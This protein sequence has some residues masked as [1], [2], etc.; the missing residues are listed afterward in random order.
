MACATPHKDPDLVQQDRGSAEEGSAK[1]ALFG[2][3]CHILQMSQCISDA[4]EHALPLIEHAR[5]KCLGKKEAGFD[6]FLYLMR[7]IEHSRAW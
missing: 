6:N 4:L 3:H 5:D 7:K 1:G 2:T